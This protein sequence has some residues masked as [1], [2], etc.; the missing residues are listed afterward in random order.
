MSKNNRNQ[1]KKITELKNE[2]EKQ[3][4]VSKFFKYSVIAALSLAISF[5]IGGFVF[6]KI[7]SDKIDIEQYQV[8]TMKKKQ[9]AKELSPTANKVDKVPSSLSITFDNGLKVKNGKYVLSKDDL[10]VVFSVSGETSPTYTQ[11]QT[12]ML[13][14][15]NF[16]AQL[17]DG[18][19]VSEDIVLVLNDKENGKYVAGQRL[20]KDNIALFVSKKTTEEN[21]SEDKEQITEILK[22]ATEWGGSTSVNFLGMKLSDEISDISIQSDIVKISIGNNDLYISPFSQD[23][24]GAGFD[25][26]FKAGDISVKYSDI[27]DDETGYAPYLFEKDKQTYKILSKDSE[28]IKNLLK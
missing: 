23:Y 11:S 3:K 17:I 22:S 15:E 21:I 4:K 18:S 5:S 13:I 9:D 24:E 14:D 8:D 10:S 1:N 2:I 19:D 26:E 16:S 25:N 20:L 27:V 7:Q 6:F 12:S 28:H